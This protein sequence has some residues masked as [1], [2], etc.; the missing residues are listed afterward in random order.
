MFEDF[1]WRRGSG[2]LGV[3]DGFAELA[4]KASEEA[5][6]EVMVVI[7][8]P[9]GYL[10]VV[11]STPEN[12]AKRDHVWAPRAVAKGLR[13][14]RQWLRSLEEDD[15]EIRKELDEFAKGRQ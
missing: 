5:D 4:R 11:A 6:A 12:P 2:E 13:L 14:L 1:K 15:Q 10:T 7:K 9:Q 3:I 8:F